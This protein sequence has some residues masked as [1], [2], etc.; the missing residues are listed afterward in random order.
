MRGAVDV[1][2][3]LVE[4]RAELDPRDQACTSLILH[5]YHIYSFVYVRASL[6]VSN[7]ACHRGSQA[8]PPLAHARKICAAQ[9]D[10]TASRCHERQGGGG[11][12]PSAG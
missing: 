5:H 3:A 7:I 12:S 1:V 9:T 6:F 11:A 4:A 2:R 8:V 10:A